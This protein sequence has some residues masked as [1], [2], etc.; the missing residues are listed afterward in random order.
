MRF[1]PLALPLP[2]KRKIIEMKTIFS[3]ITTAAAIVMVLT[4]V[5]SCNEKKFRVDGNITDAKDSTLYFENVSLDGPQVIDSVKLG[6]DGSFSFAEKTTPA[7][8]FYRLRIASQII[9]IAID[10]TETVT[11]KAAYKDMA[12]NYQVS[13]SYDCTKIQELTY[14]QMSLQQKVNSIANAPQLGVD[15]VNDSVGKVMEVYKNDVKINYIYKEPMKAYAYFAL[16]QTID[17]N[18]NEMLIFNP[19][20]SDEDVKV[21]AA[22]ATSWDT[23]YPKA[24]RGKNLHNIAIE[25]MKTVR[26]IRNKQLQAENID[27]S[28]INTSGVIDIALTDNKGNIRKLTETRGKVVLLDFHMFSGDGSL[29]RIM[30]L[31]DIYNKYHS[32]GFEIYQVSVDPDEHFWKTQTAALPW[33]CVHATDADSQVLMNYNV[34]QVPTFFLLNKNDEVYKRDAQIKDLDAEISSLL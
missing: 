34:Q 8:E 33:I 22:V 13:G 12:S 10:S 3:K 27:P 20:N 5:T 32:R 29:Q 16:F 24:E 1:A 4:A 7:P 14:K 18:G 28:K 9:N 6:E 19:R 30:K 26:I 23:F 25:G 11:V 17:I 31:R 15:A 2:Y 21:F